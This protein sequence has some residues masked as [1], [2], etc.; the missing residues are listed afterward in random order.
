MPKREARRAERDPVHYARKNRHDGVVT[1]ARP[2]ASRSNQPV[3]DPGLT[4][5]ANYLA[6]LRD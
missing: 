6:S 1:V 5:W 2:E 4:S 3:C